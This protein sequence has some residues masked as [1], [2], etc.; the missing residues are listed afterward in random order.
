MRG[1]IRISQKPP[2]FDNYMVRTDNLQLKIMPQATEP[3]WKR[4]GWEEEESQEWTQ[5]RRESNE[6]FALY[7][8]P[9]EVTRVIRRKMNAHIAKV[10][11]Y[12]NDKSTGHHLLDKIALNGTVDDCATFNVARGT[13]LQDKPEKENK[14]PKEYSP[15]LSLLKIDICTHVLQVTCVDVPNSKKLPEGM[16]F[17]LIFCCITSEPLTKD[18]HFDLVGT[19]K[20]GKFT[21]NLNSFVPEDGKTYTVH[22]YGRYLSNNGDLGNPGHTISAP[23]ILK[24]S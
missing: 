17:A 4:Y 8:D 18:S 16:A 6:L 10:R 7:N 3:N 14:N 19:S 1:K 11:R 15:Y 22:Y 20:Y 5:F 23:L 13:I 24:N 21:S 12:D 2:E 9:D